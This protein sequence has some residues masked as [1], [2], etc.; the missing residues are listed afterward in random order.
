M[1]TVFQFQIWQELRI[2]LNL[3]KVY[4]YKMV[5]TIPKQTCKMHFAL[6]SCIEKTIQY[7]SQLHICMC[8]NPL[9][10]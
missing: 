1:R 2:P 5:K 3:R 9:Y 7:F 4:I 10:T 6:D 8:Y